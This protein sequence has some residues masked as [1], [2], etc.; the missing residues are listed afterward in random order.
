MLAAILC[1]TVLLGVIV[2]AN[3]YTTGPVYSNQSP[4]D[5][6]TGVV[7]NPL[8]SLK[9]DDPDNI[10]TASLKMYVDGVQV[11]ANIQVP[12]VWTY[13]AFGNPV[14][15]P[16]YTKADISYQAA[17]LASGSHTVKIDLAD[18]AGNASSVAW[19]FTV[20]TGTVPVT[21]VT[22]NKTSTSIYVGRTETLTATVQPADA[23]DKSLVWS[24]DN[25]AVA[26]VDRN[27]T[28]TGVAAGVAT[29]TVTTT[30]GGKTATCSITVSAPSLPLFT[31][32]SPAD[33]SSITVMNPPVSADV[34]DPD[35]L[36]AATLQVSID[37][38]AVPN[39]SIVFT[40]NWAY[41]SSGNPIEVTDYTKG[42]ITAQPAGLA[43]GSHTLRISIKDRLGFWGESETSFSIV[44][45]AY[46]PVI[47]NQNPANGAVVKVSQPAISAD[48]KG[49]NPINLNRTEMKI[50]GSAVL[51]TYTA[52][53]SVSGTVYYTPASVLSNETM[54]TVAL[55]VYDNMGAYA[56][57]T[58]SFY[59]NVLT[60]MQGLLSPAECMACHDV[61]THPVNNCTAC[62]SGDTG[63][64]M[65][66]HAGAH[67]PEV[68]TTYRNN[69]CFTCHD[70]NGGIT[71]WR[72]PHNPDSQHTAPAALTDC[73]K[74][75][76]SQL[77]R[78]HNRYNL[79]CQTCHTSTRT[80]V[81]LAIK[82]L[83]SDC[84]ACHTGPNHTQLHNSIYMD[85]S[86]YDCS[87][88]HL[89]NLV[90]EH[91]RRTDAA[92]APYNCDT[93]H[94]SVARAGV[95]DAVYNNDT[96][97]TACHVI[98]PD[99]EAVHATTYIT[100]QAVDC[101]LC[102][103]N[104][105]TRIHLEYKD[106]AGNT[107]LNCSTCHNST[108]SDVQTAVYNGANNLATIYCD[109]CHNGLTTGAEAM[110]A[111]YPAHDGIHDSASGYG[112]YQVNVNGTVYDDS[113]VSCVNCHGSLELKATHDEHPNVTC[114]TC[115]NS[116]AQAVTD[117]IQGNWSRAAVK[118]GYTCSSCHNSLPYLHN[119]LH[120]V[121][122]YTEDPTDNSCGACHSMDVTAQLK[123]NVKAHANCDTCH[124]ANPALPNTGL[125]ITAN[126]SSNAS[127]TGYT[128]V[129]CHPA[130]THNHLVAANGY[131]NAPQWN[132]SK[133]HSTNADG[134]AE[135]N[136]LHQQM[137]DKGHIANF[138]C[139][140]CHNSTFEGVGKVIV[141]DGVLDM[142]QNGTTLIYCD[143][144]HNGTLVHSVHTDVTA[145]HLTSIFPTAADSDCL[146]CH[147]T[148][149]A[150]FVST[151]GGYHAANGLV[152]K[153]SGWG[154][155]I[156]GWAYNSVIGCKDCHGSDG[157]SPT[158]AYAN[159]LKKPYTY[160]S[161]SGQSE[162]L[163]FL[164]H[165][166]YTYGYGGGSTGKTGFSNGS[167]NFHNIG[168][169]KVNHVVQCS[170]CHGAVPHS[171]DRAHLM[172]TRSEPNSAGSVLTTFYHP[173][174][175][176]YRKS[177]CGSNYSA[178]DEH[179]GY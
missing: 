60:P 128:C 109:T 61:N 90:D 143:T 166:R 89:A 68:I 85:I 38:T 53:D 160:T 84:S 97:C 142:K 158:T 74:C 43:V 141:G 50:D 44:Q 63:S 118:T 34:S 1:L 164:C 107:P 45:Q 86:P 126:L 125:V 137:A 73:F 66:C 16:D 24:S 20:G 59:V 102:H 2:A 163:C 79:N 122:S 69:D 4:A 117:V 40:K 80:D 42:T 105:L 113:G 152:S 88:C 177:S 170:W 29:I 51:Y 78:E 21:G 71:G 119:K 94:S 156:N 15:V 151:K 179:S 135:L 168:D 75:H 25:T 22:L 70:S 3:A 110:G 81:Q 13:D 149:A 100:I 47:W 77:T 178:C 133:C 27:G 37:G 98:H 120:T 101:A 26:T 145:P 112:A 76:S 32:I 111:K 28:V 7:S 153:A 172:V 33:G 23:T 121:N 67:G 95:A 159:I 115:H 129:S 169:H 103:Q 18:Q 171:T 52:T 132:C 175:G 167:T 9:A 150:E 82:T 99:N 49:S 106:S 65:T 11:A 123:A 130:V 31:N 14:Q 19:S 83:N 162:M 127:R 96:R 30:D 138:G 92:G 46:A 176:Q 144:C 155:Y 55:T 134:S 91:F 56:T 161:N 108:L 12:M 174:S 139:A 157:I 8:I 104:T 93:C 39:A 57:S 116:A 36:D 72:L 10:N 58:W 148:Q 114:A 165:D 147:T 62:H 87:Q 131:D 140:I 124:G 35:G 6:A 64:C 48:V 146:K 136:A 5:G 41:D 154:T 173:A 17:N 54:H